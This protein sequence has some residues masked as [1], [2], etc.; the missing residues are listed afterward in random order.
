[1]NEYENN[2]I[3]EES[4]LFDII[5]SIFVCQ[6]HISYIF[7]RRAFTS[8]I[9]GTKIKDIRLKIIEWLYQNMA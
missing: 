5:P 8:H 3:D 6:S 2:T 1:M 9:N 7:K 4:T